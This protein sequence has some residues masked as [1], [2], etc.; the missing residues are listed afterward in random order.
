MTTLPYRLDR[1]ITIRAPRETVFS[2]FTTNER[3]ASWW[4]A[5]STIE[6]RPGGRVHIQ[7]PGGTQSVGE[8]LEV[9][10]PERL[11]FTYG[12][13]SGQPIPPG[14]SR[15]TIRLDA[16]P[17]GTRLHLTH[18]FAE[19]AAVAE[20]TQGW[21]YQLSVFANVVANEVHRD[22]GRLVD[23]W[24][25]AW[26]EPDPE[27]CRRMLAAVAAPP[28]AFRDRFSHVDGLD[29]LVPHVL[30]AQR[31]MPGFRIARAGD[32]R[33]CQ[34]VVLADWTATGPDGQ[35]R[36]AGTNVFTLGPDGKIESATGFWN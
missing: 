26:S 10:A 34:G 9:A 33:Q 12:Y 4:G 6:A 17:G 23:G 36:G 3:W 21:R 18:E 24:F 35:P 25:S 30:A 7:H 8:V 1:T 27:A 19:D 5:G 29:D 16:G 11:V 32:V 2:F 31:F 22:A 20:H 28:V 14:G 15:V 13:A